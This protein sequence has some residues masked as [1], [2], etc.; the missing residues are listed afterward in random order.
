[1][2][3][4]NQYYDGVEQTNFNFGM[5]KIDG[6]FELHTNLAIDEFTK[7]PIVYAVGSQLHDD[8]DNSFF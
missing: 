4:F 7:N 5:E 2:N 6:E 8:E 1:M 3:R